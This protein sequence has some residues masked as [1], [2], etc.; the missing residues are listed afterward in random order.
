MKRVSVVLAIVA[1]CTL[2]AVNASAQANFALRGIGL[3]AGIVEPEDVDMTLGLGLVF[4]LGT[5][6]PRV[7]V[8][9]YAG[10]WSQTEEAYGA[11]YGVRDY[12]FGAKAKYMF[13]TSNPTLQPYLGG[14]LGLHILEAHAETAPISF[15]GS[16]IVPGYSASETDLKIG[17]DLGGGLRIDRGQKF[18]FFGEGW[19]TISEVSHF[20][21]MAGATYMFGR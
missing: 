20:S 14:G 5:V 8:E 3:K 13:P 10:F 16:I 21:L 1:V 9:S 12:S 7:A 2:I 18:A 4:D 15:G 17:M 19:F 11:E 6:H